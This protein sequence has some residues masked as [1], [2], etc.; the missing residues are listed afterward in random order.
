MYD[1]KNNRTKNNETKFQSTFKVVIMGYPHTKEFID[2][3]RIVM[4]FEGGKE[5]NS[6]SNDLE[7]DNKCDI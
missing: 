5:E 1:L 7:Q 2:T 4:N 6:I 3:L